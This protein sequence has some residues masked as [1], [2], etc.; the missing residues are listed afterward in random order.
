MHHRSILVTSHYN[1]QKV[2]DPATQAGIK[3]L[4]KQ[5]ASEIPIKIEEIKSAAGEFKKVD[6]VV[7]DDDQIL[8]DSLTNFLKDRFTGVEAYYHPNRFLKNLYQYAKDTIICMDHDFKA[9][10]DG[11]ELAKQLYEAGY[12]K[13]YLL[14]GKTFEKG[15][16]PNY[17]TVLLKGDT[18]SL[19][20]LV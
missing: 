9:K 20:K 3:I 4:P 15:E 17:L 16:V 12:K 8:A 5:L 10:I 2:R 19:S 13:L 1:S 18:E 14:S 7:I 11:I 6:L